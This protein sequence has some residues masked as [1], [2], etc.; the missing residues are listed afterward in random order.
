VFQLCFLLVS[1]YLVRNCYTVCACFRAGA[2]T[3]QVLTRYDS[4]CA[5]FFPPTPVT[6]PSAP[7]YIPPAPIYI[8]STLVY[9]PSMPVYIPPAPF[10]IPSPLVYI[11]SPPVYIPPAPVYIPPVPIN[12]PSTPV[13]IPPAPVYILSTRV[14]NFQSTSRLRLCLPHKRPHPSTI[15]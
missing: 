11:P 1:A 7:V 15:C 12:I 9:I 6:I 10:Y 2:N 5:Y 3:F 8:L 14:P 13:Y 4:I